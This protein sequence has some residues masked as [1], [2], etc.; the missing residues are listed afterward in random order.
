MVGSAVSDVLAADQTSP[1]LFVR[2]RREPPVQRRCGCDGSMTNGTMK[3]K[4]LAATVRFV[5]SETVAPLSVDFWMERPTYSAK[6]TLVFVGSTATAPPSPPWILCQAF[7]LPF[8]PRSVPLSW[9]PPM[10]GEPA[11]YTAP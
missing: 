7:G 2:H 9:V 5:A 8:T 4:P 11:G 1:W 10:N 6:R 3:R